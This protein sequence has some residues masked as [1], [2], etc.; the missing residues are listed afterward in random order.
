[1]EYATF[2]ELLN[3]RS[4]L[5]SLN[6]LLPTLGL[7]AMQRLDLTSRQG[8]APQRPAWVKDSMWRLCQHL[9]AVLPVFSGISR[10]LRNNHAQWNIFK[11]SADVYSLMSTPWV[12]SDHHVG[13]ST[14]YLYYKIWTQTQGERIT[15]LVIVECSY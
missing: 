4:Q 9:E 10:S 5:T 14:A 3:R 6:F 7:S 1:M 13:M 2:Q 15:S 11:S 8:A 12:A